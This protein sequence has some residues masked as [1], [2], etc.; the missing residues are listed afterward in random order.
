MRVILLHILWLIPSFL[1][2]Q[3][4]DEGCIDIVYMRDGSLYRG[5]LLERPIDGSPWVIRTWSGITMQLPARMVRR[6]VQRCPDSGMRAALPKIYHFRERGWYNAT[7][8][9]AMAGQHWDNSTALGVSLHNS[10]GYAFSR[11][12]AVGLGFGV[13]VFYP[14]QEPLNIATY[15]VYAELRG[16]LMAR[17]VTP[18]YAVG[19]GWGFAGRK[20]EN[21]WGYQ[22]DW[23]GGWFGQAMLGYRLGNHFTIQGGLHFQRQTRAWNSIWDLSYGE[24][25]ILYRRFVLGFGL[26]I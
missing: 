3:T 4:P 6:V 10:A 24:D 1:L 2:A 12:F 17:R 25:R 5:Q 21:R 23:Q 9:A 11:P 18:F 14:Y 13:D 26:L 8:I 15:P 20:T 22:D 7:T 16:Y 19:G